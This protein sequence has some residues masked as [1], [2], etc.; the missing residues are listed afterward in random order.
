MKRL[1]AVLTASFAVLTMV[2][3]STPAAAGPAPKVTARLAIDSTCNATVYVT[4]SGMTSPYT[5]YQ[6]NVDLTGEGDQTHWSLEAVPLGGSAK[7]KATRSFQGAVS[8]VKQVNR[9]DVNIAST[10]MDVAYKTA[11]C[12]WS[13]S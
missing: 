11:A 7:G 1:I 8:D 4:W 13:Q 5:L 3:L 9:V 6:V 2:G 12:T 10:Y